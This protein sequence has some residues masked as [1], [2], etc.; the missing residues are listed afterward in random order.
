V[1][2]LARNEALR[3]CCRVTIQVPPVCSFFFINQRVGHQH[4]FMDSTKFAVFL[5]KQGG[6]LDFPPF[7]VVHQK[8][9]SLIFI[10]FFA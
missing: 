4:K 8:P 7:W 1:G 9:R 10:G 3:A 2:A 6:N 5:P